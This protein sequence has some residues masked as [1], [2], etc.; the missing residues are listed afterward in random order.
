MFQHLKR[1]DGKRIKI[2]KQTDDGFLIAEEDLKLRGYGDLTGFQQ[3]GI[4]NFKFADPVIHDDLFK[5]AENEIRRI[6]NKNESLLKF[7]PLIK[8]YDQAEIINDLV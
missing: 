5:L 3:S 8:L 7:K 2:L 1:C 6:E 4:K